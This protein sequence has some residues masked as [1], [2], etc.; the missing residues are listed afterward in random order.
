MR[1]EL[2]LFFI[3]FLTGCTLEAP[4]EVSELID[5]DG[6]CVSCNKLIGYHLNSDD[7]CVEDTVE[8]CGK[9]LDDCTAGKG[10]TVAECIKGECKV[11]SCDI[12]NGYIFESNQCKLVIP[13]KDTDC[14]LNH[15]N[16]MSDGVKTATC[17]QEMNK[18]SW[19]CLN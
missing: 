6:N 11:L 2:W 1:R 13:M 10:I 17:G 7:V 4:C 19:F 14:S 18:E 15:Y 5:E 16:C 3:C 8:E 12:D 9:G